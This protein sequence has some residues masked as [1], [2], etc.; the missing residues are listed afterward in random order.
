MSLQAQIDAVELRVQEAC[1]RSGRSREDVQIIAVTKYASLDRTKQVLALGCEHIGENRWQDARDKWNKLGSQGTWHFIGHLQSNKVKDVIDKFTYIHSLDRMSLAR[2]IQKK[3][4]EWNR[5]VQCFIQVNV[6][7][8]QTKFG[9]APNELISFANQ[10]SSFSNLRI[11]GLMTMAPYEADPEEIRAYFRKLRMLKDELNDA[12]IWP[13]PIPHL[14][15]GMSN[16]F[17]IAIEEGATW[18]RLGSIF[19]GKEQEGE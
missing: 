9:L 1:K 13:Y 6:S 17:E 18:I 15:M 11:V 7:G 10:I 8:E 12:K 3:A 16:D 2:A 5:I 14:S 19:V 4:D